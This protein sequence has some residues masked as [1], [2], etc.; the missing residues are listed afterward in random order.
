MRLKMKINQN[1][2]RVDVDELLPTSIKFRRAVVAPRPRLLLPVVVVPRRSPRSLLAVV[3]PQWRLRSPLAVVVPRRSPRSR[4]VDALRRMQRVDV[5]LLP[6][7]P[8]VVV[9]ADKRQTKG[10]GIVLRLQTHN[11]R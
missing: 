5:A 8:R 10:R 3:V 7:P 11:G 4:R 6:S 2:L 1:P 9:A